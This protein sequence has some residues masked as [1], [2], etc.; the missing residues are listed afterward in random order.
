MEDVLQGHCLA[1]FMD[2]ILGGSVV[3]RSVHLAA[4][5]WT[6]WQARNDV[7]WRCSSLSMENLKVQVVQSQTL[8][9]NALS[10]LSSLANRQNSVIHWSPPP[11]NVLKCN[12]DAAI[13][14]DGASYGVVVR[15]H[16]G[17][18]VAAR[19][20][21]ITCTREPLI[22]EVLAAY[23]SLKWLSGMQHNRIILDSD[24]LPFCNSFNS[25]T[26][27]YSYEGLIVKQ[28]LS[29]ARDIGDVKVPIMSGDQRT[30]WLT[31]L[32]GQ[33]VLRLSPSR[34]LLSH[35][36]VLRIC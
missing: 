15:D 8:W 23:E 3:E 10:G 35:L 9:K 6:L 19:S 20:G 34:G 17:S 31:N 11:H 27:D 30:M 36:L 22:A 25:R 32:H 13:F 24:C 2:S 4:V 14:A 26:I 1:S 33:L 18:F 16:F 28:C 21:W 29:I 5:F 12:V 7:V